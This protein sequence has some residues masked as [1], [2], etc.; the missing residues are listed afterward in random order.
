MAVFLAAVLCVVDNE[1]ENARFDVRTSVILADSA[2]D[3][4][5]TALVEWR[6]TNPEWAKPTDEIIQRV[7]ATEL[8]VE[9][10]SQCASCARR[11]A[12][13]TRKS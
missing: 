2:K 4:E 9:Q 12:E 13:I 11:E 8:S 6:E 1:G 5:A 7:H 3:A 10:L